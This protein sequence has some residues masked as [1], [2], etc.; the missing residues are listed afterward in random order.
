MRAGEAVAKDGTFEVTNRVEIPAHGQ[1]AADDMWA[2]VINRH[3]FLLRVQE[4]VGFVANGCNTPSQ[5]DWTDLLPR[6]RKWHYHKIS[7]TLTAAGFFQP[8]GKSW[9]SR[10]Y[11]RCAE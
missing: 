1:L 9:T 8:S 2:L 6:V 4:Q 11:E 10:L 5:Y 7:E 3:P